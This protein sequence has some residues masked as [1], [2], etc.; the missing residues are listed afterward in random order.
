MSAA[1]KVLVVDDDRQMVKTVSDILRLKGYETVKAY[2]GEEAIDKVKNDGPDC[3][4]MDLKMAGMNGVETLK[5]I[6]G[7]SPVTRVA[8]ISA[9]VT[10]EQ[11]KEAKLH[12]ATMVLTK[13]VDFTQLLAF[14]ALLSE[15]VLLT[16][17]KQHDSGEI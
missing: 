8:L 13:P 16:D 17:G 9:Y 2:S 6:K 1:L 15:S 11:A 7:I 3:V 14:L 12:G 4:L 10:D 5:M